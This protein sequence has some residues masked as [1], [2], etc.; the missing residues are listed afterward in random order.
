MQYKNYEYIQ[1]ASLVSA[2]VDELRLPYKRVCRAHPLVV[3]VENT[4]DAACTMFNIF[5]FLFVTYPGGV[6]RY[7]YGQ[8]RVFGEQV[9]VADQYAFVVAGYSCLVF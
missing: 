8:K 6:Q 5:S 1:A 2:T 3:L 4:W 9:M 7:V